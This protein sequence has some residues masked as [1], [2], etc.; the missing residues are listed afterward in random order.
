MENSCSTPEILTPKIATPGMLE[1]RV[2][3]NALPRV[4][5]CPLSKG[6]MQ[7]FAVSSVGFL[8]SDCKQCT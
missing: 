7:N 2:R 4:T 8:S 3:R 6:S 1:S 5:P